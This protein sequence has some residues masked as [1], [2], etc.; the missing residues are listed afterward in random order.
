LEAFGGAE[1][2]VSVSGSCGAMMKVFYP[3]L[4]AGDRDEKAANEVAAATHEF[5]DFLV[6]VLKV[7]DVGARFE[8]KATFHDGCHG[9]RELGLRAPPRK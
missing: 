2:I 7:G 8:A 3:Q 4:F 9:L 6:N 5:S 1:T